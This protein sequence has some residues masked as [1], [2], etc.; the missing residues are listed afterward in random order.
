MCSY[1]GQ[2]GHYRLGFYNIQA[3]SLYEKPLLTLPGRVYLVGSNSDRRSIW[4]ALI[5]IK[6][7]FIRTILTATYNET[8]PRDPDLFHKNEVWANT[9]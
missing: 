9:S 5:E 2:C 6:A 4:T 1:F 8:P 7:L 3:L